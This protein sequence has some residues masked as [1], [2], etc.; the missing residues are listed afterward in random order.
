MSSS[1]QPHGLWHARP[2]CPLPSPG[3]H[4]SSRPLSRWCHPTISSS[5]ALFSSCPQCFPASGSFPVSQLIT[6]SG[7]SIGAS[8]SA[9]VLPISIQGWFPLRLKTE[10]RTCYILGMLWVL[11]W[12]DSHHKAK[13][14][15]LL[16]PFSR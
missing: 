13:W 2:P 3:V 9:S 7:Q 10:N 1:L 12:V 5:A 14:T 16:F 8:A 15:Q 11:K 6:S 4:P